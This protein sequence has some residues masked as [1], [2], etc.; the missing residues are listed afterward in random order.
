MP[1]QYIVEVLFNSVQV[2]HHSVAARAQEACLP[3]LSHLRLEVELEMVEGQHLAVEA[4][5]L[6]V[7][8]LS[9]SVL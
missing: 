1:F 8:E 3:E 6:Q 7:G 9:G 5:Y 2:A 4:F